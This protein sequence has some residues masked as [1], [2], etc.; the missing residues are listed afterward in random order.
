M[1]ESQDDGEPCQNKMPPDGY[2]M[3]SPP[4]QHCN[5]RGDD[6][7]QQRDKTDPEDHRKPQNWIVHDF[8]RSQKPHLTG[9]IAVLLSFQTL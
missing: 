4:V 8:C 1:N 9:F 2:R 5:H 7:Q 3:N 6:K